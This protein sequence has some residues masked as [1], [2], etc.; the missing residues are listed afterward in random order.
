MQLK[1]SRLAFKVALIYVIVAG[2]WIFFSDELVG[3]L[4]PNPEWRFRF[5]LIKGW[6]FVLVTGGLL[7]QIILR[8]VTHWERET[9]ERQRAEAAQQQ[10]EK[11]YQRLFAAATDA[12]ILVDNQSNQI[13]EV[14]A[15][16]E[17]M[18]GYPRAEFIRLKAMEVSAEPEKTWDAIAHKHRQIPLRWHRRKDG[19]VF[20]VEIFCN[21]FDEQERC[22]HVAVIRDITERKRIELA[23]QLSDFSVNGV[24]MPMFW[25]TSDARVVRVNRA[26]CAHLGYTENE[27]LQLVV[28]DFDP[29]FPVA[30]WAEHWQELRT[31]KHLGLQTWHRHKDGHLIPVELELS[32]FE[33]DGREYNFAFARDITERKRAEAALRESEQKFAS[34]FASNPVAT[35]VS[36]WA[37]GRYL[38]VNAAWL[39]IF[40]RTRA[41]VLGHTVHELNI[42]VDLAQRAE[43]FAHVAQHGEV[44]D[45]EMNLR[46]KAGEPLL[47]L[48]SGVRVKFGGTDCLL[49]SALDITERKLAEEQ[50]R[51]SEARYRQLFEME[52]DAV[53]LVDSATHR[54][55][56]VNLSTQRLYGYTR[57]EFL[58]MTP[59]DVSAEP[60]LTRAH[61][62]S[63]DGHV[64][65]R[66]HRKKNGEL[67]AVEINANQIIYQGRP[68]ALVALRDITERKRAEETLRESQAL[69][70]SLITQLPVGIFRKN[71][72]GRYVL[73]NPGFCQIKGVPAEKFLGKTPLE[74]YAGETRGAA[75]GHA[76]RM[77]AQGDENHR[78]IMQD[79]QL[80]KLEEEG[81]RADG[82]KIFLHVIKFPV[83]DPAGR[84]V[85]SQG[86]L[87]DI[88]ERK[89]SEDQLRKLSRTVEQSPVAVAIT[90]VNGKMEYVN[91]AFTRVTGYS[92]QQAVGKNPRILKSGQT[93]RETY[94]ELW[95]TITA[96]HIWNG[97]LLNRRKDGELFWE[98]AAI[99]PLLD[100]AGQ[101]THYIAVKED[102]TERKQAENE[103]RW[104]TAFLEAQVDSAADGILVVDG[105]SKKI[106]Q[107]RRFNELFKIPPHIVVDPDGASQ[108]LFVT[109]QTKNPED[110]AEKISYLSKHPDAVGND[111]FELRDGTILHRHS[112]PV[113]DKFGKYYG[114]I[115]TFRDVTKDRQLEAQ[116]RQAQKME[117][118]GTL[119]GG[120]AHDFNNILASMF[121]Y[122][123]LLQQDTAGNAAAQED[124]AEI[125]KAASRAKD[126]V[127]QILTFSR[128]REQKRQIIPLD[129]VVKEAMKFLRASLPAEIKIEVA[130]AEDAPTVLADPTQ[131]YQVTMNLATNALH[132]MDDR[133]GQLNVWLQSFL[134]EEKFI[135]AHPEFQAIQYARLTIADTGHG[136]DAKTL[137]RMFEPFFTTKPVGKGTGLG[138]AVVHGIVQS[139]E[140]IITV[141]ST[142]GKGTTFD[143][144]FPAR[145]SHGPQTNVVAD[146][147]TTGGGQKILL[148]DDEPALTAP[149]QRLLERLKYQVTVSNNPRAAV[150]LI[151]QN[152]AHFDLVITDLTMPEMNGFEVA[153][154]LHVFRADLPIILVSGLSS[155]FTR[156]K[157]AAAGITELLEKPVSMTTLAEVLQRTLA[158]VSAVSKPAIQNHDAPAIAND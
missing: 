9:H 8:L 16:A 85:G 143:L 37:E 95:A 149:F 97:E 121:G 135:V 157:V 105:D 134:P 2:G 59:E 31:Q 36:T 55:L 74:V 136:M 32:W 3:W 123:Y 104:K 109:N 146:T 89:K 47:I 48:W 122:G 148:L 126:L 50:L 30:R 133:P 6:V 13:L 106:L 152:P 98:R 84:V 120:I 154:Q 116:L 72:A 114:R 61:I 18:Y 45:F 25:V 67:F 21:E 155:D 17:K 56:D 34:I 88:T 110:F 82:Q 156:E 101:I 38:D 147:V 113:R 76:A 93:P 28:K 87:F 49:G 128:Q 23:L 10:S 26:A 69:Y 158:N 58:Q 52:S 44:R 90:D 66:W 137:E 118:I 12:M 108:R 39:K 81:V 51:E 131:I 153:R 14:N 40:Q 80:I 78:Q 42:W 145:T 77:A 107:N 57:E 86:V 144:Y 130:V 41:E 111:V 46:T 124:L 20:P 27:L 71:A 92:A 99:A 102:I 73:V 100:S 68:T 91:A 53:I 62:N 112:A 132:A 15:A 75:D 11:R 125:L 117:A 22:I 94:A 141:E 139:H 115:W 79:G 65:M 96:G 29:D 119:A 142:V 83:F 127:Q 140:G 129:T 151:R 24:S 60:E 7:H 1:A 64:P 103:L 35:S 150:E 19:A 70:H 138:L 54:Y 5:S 63:A 4:V 33:F 43:L